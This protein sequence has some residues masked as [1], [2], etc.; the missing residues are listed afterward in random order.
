MYHPARPALLCLLLA[1]ASAACDDSDNTPDPGPAGGGGAAGAGGPSDPGPGGFLLTVSGEDLALNGYPFADGKSLASDPAFVDGWAVTFTHVLLTV[2]NP[3]LHD[4]PDQDPG[5][6]T[7][8][9]SEVARAS[10][11]WAVDVARRGSAID[12]GSGQPG[13]HAIASWSQTASGQPFDLTRRYALSY[14]LDV[15]TSTATR[16][17]FDAD[18][19]ALY[20]QAIAQ[21]WSIVFAGQATYQGPAPDPGSVFA[22]LPK[23]VSFTLGLTRTASYVNC[24]NPDLPVG[25]DGDF[26]RG[27]QAL[28][29]QSQVVQLTF[30][31][32]HLFWDALDVEGTP[33]HFDPIAAWASAQ[34]SVSLTD[35]ASADF[36]AFTTRQ[37]EPLL[38]RSQVDDVKLSA[39]QLSYQANGAGPFS[40][41]NFASYLS[42]SALF[43]GHLNA[44]GECVVVPR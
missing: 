24:Q 5:N 18:S 29:N 30:H 32:D 21:S 23:T 39:V 35:L 6:P 41:N 20:Q 9:G 3:R 38:A 4:N 36:T 44:D 11:A 25:A 28:A 26:P 42:Y 14:D 8:L 27:V 12:K 40:K 1:V 19:E 33:L 22:T 16:V 34:G 37:G 17:G 10:G 31:T 13:A 15:A 2:A 7:A 43:G